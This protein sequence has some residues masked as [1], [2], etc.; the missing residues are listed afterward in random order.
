MFNKSNI[1]SK[2]H[3]IM[4]LPDIFALCYIKILSENIYTR[5]YNLYLCQQS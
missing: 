3:V 4:I 1:C 2:C 5:D